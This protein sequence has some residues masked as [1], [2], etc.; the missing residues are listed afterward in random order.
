MESN[1]SFIEGIKITDKIIALTSNSILPL[2][3]DKLVFYNIEQR[4]E[5]KQTIKGSFVHNTNGLAL[6]EIKANETNETKEYKTRGM[7]YF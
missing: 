3:E 4:K 5:E 1:K 7:E 6:V 2:G